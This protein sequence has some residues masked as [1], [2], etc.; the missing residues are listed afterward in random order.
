MAL[1]RTTTPRDVGNVAPQGN[2]FLRLAPSLAALF[3]PLALAALHQCGLQLAQAPE[4]SNKV[5]AGIL[6]SFAVAL[7]YSVPA[8]SLVAILKAGDDIRT[9]RLAH[10]AFAA[11]PLFVFIGV[12]FYMLNIP[13]GD[14]VLWGIAWLGI[15]AF[16]ALAPTTTVPT[17]PAA[18]WIRIAHGLS[19]AAII[20]IFLAWHLA[21]HI[22]AAFSMDVN[23]QMMD[24]LR[25]WY[26]SSFVQPV[27]VALFVFQLLSGLR[28]LWAKT[29]HKA[30]IYS[31]IQTATGGYLAV[32]IVSHLFAVFVFGRI[33]Q[34]IDTTFPWASGAPTGLL[35]DSWNVRLIPHY[36]LAVLFVVSHSAMGLRTV[37]LAHGV[38]DVSANRL[39]WITCGFG[40][41]V[42]LVITFGQLSVG[43]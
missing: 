1:F 32:Y 24:V 21:N 7:V 10:L 6:L 8:L 3:Y 30:D 28:L 23:K 39:T 20:V 9:R 22:T 17:S 15:I 12:L 29:A 2:W 33:F 11:P 31:S 34:G 41:A 26:R 35:L 13:N 25:T 14:Y 19:A 42:S 43:G 5:T 38:H 4:I 27:L 36:S 18:A 16:A 37:L 40:L